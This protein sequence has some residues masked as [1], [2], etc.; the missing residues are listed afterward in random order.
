MQLGSLIKKT[1]EASCLLTQSLAQGIQS[2]PSPITLLGKFCST[3][4][5]AGKEPHYPS[6]VCYSVSFILA[7]SCSPLCTVI[8][9]YLSFTSSPLLIHWSATTWDPLT[10]EVKS[11]D[12]GYSNNV[13]VESLNPGIHVNLLWAVKPIQTSCQ[14]ESTSSAALCGGI[15]GL[16]RRSAW[17]GSGIFW[18][19]V[20]AVKSLSRSWAMFVVWQHTLSCWGT[21]AIWVCWWHGW[22]VWSAKGVWVDGLCQVASTWLPG[23]RLSQLSITA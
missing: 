11:I 3:S 22:C 23:S 16:A 6:V 9:A 8:L 4:Q 14:T 20:D 5:S 17:V 15:H 10:G 13:A 18:G 2:K 12:H 1:N 7:L 19:Q 21:N